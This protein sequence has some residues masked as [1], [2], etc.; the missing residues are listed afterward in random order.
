MV[1]DKAYNKEYIRKVFTNKLIKFIEENGEGLY[2]KDIWDF[3][4]KQYDKEYIRMNQDYEYDEM[5][6]IFIDVISFFSSCTSIIFNPIIDVEKRFID[7][8]NWTIL[9]DKEYKQE[10]N[11]IKRMLKDSEMMEII[12][13]VNEE[14]RKSEP[15]IYLE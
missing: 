8:D 11:D 4:P 10:L 1:K 13:E 9:I 6:N 14:I 5:V 2:H 12:K 7:F 15:M 3:F